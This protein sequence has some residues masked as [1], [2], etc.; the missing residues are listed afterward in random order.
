MHNGLV[1]FSFYNWGNLGSQNQCHVWK[2]QESPHG[3]K[4]DDGDG[5]G[6]VVEER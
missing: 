6:V 4:G 3:R 1:I 2:M 5:Q